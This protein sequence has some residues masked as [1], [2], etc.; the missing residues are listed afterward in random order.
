MGLLF[1]AL[2][3]LAPPIGFLIYILRFDRIEPEPR[4]FIVRILF[5]GVLS[6]VPA[7]LMEGAFLESP[8][9]AGEGLVQAGLQSFLV[10][11][12]IEETIKL[13]VVL[14]F[15]WRSRN[16][17]EPNDGIVYAGTVSIGFAMAE[18]LL[19]VLEH[20][21][22]VG[23]ARALTAIPGHTFTGVLMGHYVGVARFAST[24]STRLG[25]LAVGL[26]LAWLLHGL[27]DT[28][29]LSGT[30]WALMV[31]PMVVLYFV[32]GVRYLKKGREMSAQRWGEDGVPPDV[33]QPPS[34][35]PGWKRILARVLL[36]ISGAVWLMII[37]GVVHDLSVG[38]G[39]SGYAVLGGVLITAVPV[40]LGLLLEASGRKA[41][42]SREN[43]G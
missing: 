39:D 21:F 29:V 1:L 37:A 23:V 25:N 19:Y 15:A 20:G 35:R 11:A 24:R 5:L 33:H 13:L 40:A 4:G 31:V 9:F 34:R 22:G 14:I 18:N 27:Y 42:K 3:A 43:R 7:A 41:A 36:S 16:F 32:V 38:A 10:I 6:V 26:I 12:P 8:L 2:L 28:L 17:N 30:A